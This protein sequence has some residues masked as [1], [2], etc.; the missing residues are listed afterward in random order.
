MDEIYASTAVRP[1]YPLL[2]LLLSLLRA[3]GTS[4]L[5]N[6]L[7]RSLAR[8]L[9]FWRFFRLDLSKVFLTQ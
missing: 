1:N 9:L 4:F 6:A 2:T 8:D 3:S 7:R 5:T